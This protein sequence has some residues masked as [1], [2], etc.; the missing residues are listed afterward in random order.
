MKINLA[1]AK[2][3]IV[4]PYRSLWHEHGQLPHPI[5]T[6]AD[7]CRNRVYRIQHDA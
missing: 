7:D 1:G 5:S 2:L 3:A 6:T 4:N